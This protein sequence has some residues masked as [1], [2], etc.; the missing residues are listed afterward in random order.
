MQKRPKNE[1]FGHFIEF[2]W[3]CVADIAYWEIIKRF[4]MFGEIVRSVKSLNIAFL[5]DP[6][7]Q[8]RDF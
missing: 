1:V 3:F 2:V 4:P 6:K 7:S 5:N 8:K